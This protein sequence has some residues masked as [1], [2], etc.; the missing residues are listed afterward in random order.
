MVLPSQILGRSALVG[1][2]LGQL[3]AL[4]DLL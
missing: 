1:S 3:V 2:D 4:T